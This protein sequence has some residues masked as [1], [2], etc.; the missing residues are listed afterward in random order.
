VGFGVVKGDFGIVVVVSIVVIFAVAIIIIIIAIIVI[1]IIVGVIG[2]GVVGKLK[3]DV[4]LLVV[5]WSMASIPLTRSAVEGR[6][7]W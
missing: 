1:V 3:Q 7:S 2:S 4:Q 5:S 6:F